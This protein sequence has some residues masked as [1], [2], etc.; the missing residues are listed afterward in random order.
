LITN[1]FTRILLMLLIFAL[2]IS[3]AYLMLAAH[4][5][6]QNFNALSTQVKLNQKLTGGSFNFYQL[7]N[8]NLILNI[9]NQSETYFSKIDSNDQLVWKRLIRA[10][11]EAV[12]RLAALR[13][14]YFL[15]GIVGNLYVL[16]NRHRRQLVVDKKCGFR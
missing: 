4:A 10:G 8:G 12:M 6:N 16:Q 5:G 14:G 1:R 13:C 11:Q 3:A 2:L 9:A 15:G 7:S